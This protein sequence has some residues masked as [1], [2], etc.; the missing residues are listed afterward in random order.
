MSLEI[1]EIGEVIR[2]VRKERGFRLED[3]ADDNISPATISNIERGVPHVNMDKTKYLLKKL[4]LDLDNLPNLMVNEQQ[5][6]EETKFELFKIETLL[7]INDRDSAYKKLKELN[8]EDSH[9]YAAIAYYLK[10]KLLISKKNW[11][12]AE[13]ALF[14]AIRLASQSSHC[15]DHNVEADAFNQ[16]GIASFRQNNIVQALK[17]TENGLD[18]FLEGENTT[19]QYL[20]KRNQAL[21]LEK[22]GRLGEAMQVVQEVWEHLHQIEEIDIILSFYWLRADLLRR[23]G[24]L[25]ESIQYAKD[26]LELARLNQK[27]HSMFDL[28]TVLGSVYMQQKQWNKAESC[29]DMALKLTGQF[30]DQ[31]KFSTTYA[32][33]GILYMHQSK[34]DEAH[35]VIQKAISISEKLNIA[36]RLT[37]ALQVMG[38]YY[39]KQK[40][41]TNATEYYQKALDLSKKYDYKETEYQTLFR[42]SQC[43]EKTDE[44]K[45]HE[46][47]R[48]MY[49]VQQDLQR[50]EGTTFEELE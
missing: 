39:R 49:K 3:L 46:S 12:R 16:L 14:N 13:R 41:Y 7:G 32:R 43:Y 48:E 26:G 15:Q 35:Q 44:A 29:F 38:D 22:L 40:K 11:K 36:P 34:W 4:D 37:Y 5:E 9:P 27:Y 50:E 18:A 42:L 33:L 45:F 17:Y 10:G 25:Q 30:S 28:W 31:D 19:L 1:H 8:L 47:L 24:M 2:K 21:Y 20:L 23:S 6:L